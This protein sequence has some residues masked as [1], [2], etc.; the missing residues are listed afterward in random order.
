MGLAPLMVQQVFEVLRGLQAGGMTMLL[1]SRTP[2]SR[3]RIA[4]RGHVIE[5]G[6]IVM[7]DAAAVLRGNDEV[8]KAYLGL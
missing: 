7:D 4:D 1:S 5:G 6:R 8:R 2:A 3:W